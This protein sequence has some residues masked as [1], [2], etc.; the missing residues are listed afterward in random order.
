M[1]QT[2]TKK[3]R[4]IWIVAPI[5]C[6]LAVYF[7]TQTQSKVD[8]P[9]YITA[10]AELGDIAVTVLATGQ[11]QAFSQVNVG[12]QASGQISQLKV[13]LGDQV[14]KD[15][16]IAE[17]NPDTQDNELSKAQ[18]QVKNNQASLALQQSNLAQARRNLARQQM[19]YAEGATSK[20]ALENA[21]TQV[22]NSQASLTQSRLQIEQSNIALKKARLNRSYTTVKAPSA[23]TVISL[24]VRAGQTINAVQVSPTI[25]TLAQLDKMVVKLE[26]SE[27]DVG[28]V[29]AGMPVHFTIMGNTRKYDSVLKSIDPAPMPVS[30][31]GNARISSGT[32]IFYY[33]TLEVP[34][35]DGALRMYMTANAVIAVE[36]V[37]NVLT[38][39]AS[40]LRGAIKNEEEKAQEKG[41]PNSVKV[42]HENGEVG[43]RHVQVGLNNGITV[44]IISGLNKGDRV[45]I[46]ESHPNQQDKAGF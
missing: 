9:Q 11:V 5:L 30:N 16:V 7:Y 45:I 15:Q 29:K 19:M 41:S 10:E 14:V 24:P 3:R 2:N 13:A 46:S 18:A 6:L 26:I 37:K 33:G 32:P 8:T 36:Q 4:Y 27:A 35:D 31:N 40:A 12:A 44:E 25:A 17:I 22:K 1:T 20:Q 42:L 34:N 43:V 39:P 23:G 21:Q 38:L 28:K